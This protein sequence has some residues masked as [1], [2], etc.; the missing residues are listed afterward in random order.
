M[1]GGGSDKDEEESADSGSEES[2][3]SQ[4]GLSESSEAEDTQEAPTTPKT[5]EPSKID[6][7]LPNSHPQ[8]LATPSTRPK[9]IFGSAAKNIVSFT[10]V[11]SSQHADFTIGPGLGADAEAKSVLFPKVETPQSTTT[12][13]E[14]EERTVFTNRA[15]LF[16]FES[17]SRE[18]KEKGIGMVKINENQVTGASRLLM[19][20]DGV[21]RVL[22]NSR[23]FPGINYSLLNERA[24]R[25]VLLRDQRPVQFLFRFKNPLETQEFLMELS[26]RCDDI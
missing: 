26:N 8:P 25:V 3:Y 18:W 17:S 7:E 13:G 22:V 23:L 5:A 6:T 1:T 24:V 12:T 9:A 19:R 2:E 15:R 11:S 21:L 16:E 4:G 10:S 20:S 14:E